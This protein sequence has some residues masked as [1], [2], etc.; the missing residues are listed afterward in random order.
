MPV[1]T[2]RILRAVT[3]QVCRRLPPE[4]E[5]L[6]ISFANH[7]NKAILDRSLK[8]IALFQRRCGI[9]DAISILFP[10]YE[11][12]YHQPGTADWY[13]YR[14]WEAKHFCARLYPM[15]PDH[16][17]FAVEPF[18]RGSAEDFPNSIYWDSDAEYRKYRERKDGLV[19]VPTIRTGSICVS[20][21]PQPPAM[22]VETPAPRLYPTNHIVV[23][24]RRQ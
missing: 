15:R 16:P 14:N 23:R 10:K 8:Y 2:D 5:K 17:S 13:Y 9:P 3:R 6:I 21:G 1:V 22:C 20:A 11:R 24:Q 18:A 12:N 4:V 7:A 19:R